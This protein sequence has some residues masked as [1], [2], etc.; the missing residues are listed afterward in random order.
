MLD[1]TAKLN[2]NLST[3]PQFD[4]TFDAEVVY[5]SVSDFH[6]EDIEDFNIPVGV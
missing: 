5:T 1:D 6:K 2:G 3:I 4:G